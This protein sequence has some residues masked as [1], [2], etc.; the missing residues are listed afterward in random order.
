MGTFLGR[1][2]VVSSHICRASDRFLNLYVFNGVSSVCK[3]T[4]PSIFF[5]FLIFVGL[6]GLLVCDVTKGVLYSASYKNFMNTW[7]GT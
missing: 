7:V 6:N 1:Y 2:H 5:A 4:S 3:H